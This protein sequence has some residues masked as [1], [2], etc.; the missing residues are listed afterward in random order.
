M[1]RSFV[2]F[3]ANLIELRRELAIW[4]GGYSLHSG[5]HR[6]PHDFG[7]SDSSTRKIWWRPESSEYPAMAIFKSVLTELAGVGAAMIYALP[8]MA[9]GPLTATVTLVTTGADTNGNTLPIQTQTGT[10]T[11][12][13]DGKEATTMYLT[14]NGTGTPI[15]TTIQWPGQ[16]I[17]VDYGKKAYQTIPHDGPIGLPSQVLQAAKGTHHTFN[18]MDCVDVPIKDRTGKVTGNACTSPEYGVA[19]YRELET[20]WAGGKI[21]LVEEMS[22]FTTVEPDPKLFQPPPGFQSAPCSNCT[23]APR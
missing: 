14:E 21:T 11:R 7:P 13:S 3:F 15:R 6:P 8:A 22:H 19:I 10:Y 17:I 20:E 4:L 16:T 23:T 5:Y 18:G 12:S 1:M 2:I 9:A